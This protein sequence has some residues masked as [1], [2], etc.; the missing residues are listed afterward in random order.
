MYDSEKI[1]AAAEEINA[2]YSP[3][4]PAMARAF[5]AEA[6]PIAVLSMLDEIEALRKDADRWKQ[7][8]AM[9]HNMHSATAVR[10]TIAVID[11]SIN[12][13]RTQGGGA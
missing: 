3:P 7:H 1:R 4:T 9:M 6:T 5:R 11:A 8:I 2:S 13:A 10:E 12:A